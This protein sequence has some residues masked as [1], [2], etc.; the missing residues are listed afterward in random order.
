MS[1]AWIL[2]IALCIVLHLFMHRGHGSH[3]R[4]GGNADDNSHRGHGCGTG[5]REQ[6][7]DPEEQVSLPVDAAHRHH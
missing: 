7:P 2:I 5:G 3:G 6:S 1:T 4:D